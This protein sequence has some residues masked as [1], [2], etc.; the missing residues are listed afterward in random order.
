MFKIDNTTIIDDTY[1]ENGVATVTIATPDGHF[2]GVARVHPDDLAAAHCNRFSGYYL[3][4]TRALIKYAKYTK[5][6]NR[7]ILHELIILHSHI[8]KK[9]P[10]IKEIEKRITQIKL[11]IGSCIQFIDEA[12]DGINEKLPALEQYYQKKDKNS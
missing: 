10:A 9:N 12:T 8:N 5:N 11:D 1:N 4:H 6:M 3:A 7:K 2:T